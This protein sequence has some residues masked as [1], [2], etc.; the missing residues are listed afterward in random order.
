[1][2]LNK[3]FRPAIGVTHQGD[4]WPA[5]GV[6]HENFYNAFL[7]TKR[8]PWAIQGRKRKIAKFFFYL[9][10]KMGLYTRGL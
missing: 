2:G 6:I 8:F 4:F 10:P 5:I 3:N 9:Q 1:M 7:R